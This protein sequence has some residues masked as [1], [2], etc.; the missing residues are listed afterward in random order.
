MKR[1]EFLEN[2]A[3]GAGVLALG[4]AVPAFT[5]EKKNKPKKEFS[6]DPTAIIPLT[7]KVSCTR[8]GFGTGMRGYY[9]ESD[10]TKMG[11]KNAVELLQFA[12]DQNVRL[13]DMADLYG[14]HHYVSRALKG[15]PRDSYAMISKVWMHPGGLHEETR[16]G[17]DVTLKR[18][19]RECNTDY[20]DILQ[21]HCMNDGEWSTR[22]AKQMDEME[23][24]KEEGLILAHGVSCHANSALETAATT[25]WVDTAHVR[26]NHE[27]VKMDGSVDDVVKVANACHD[28]GIGMIAMKVIGEGAFAD[29]LEKRKKSITF[30]SGLDC[31]DVMIVGFYKKEHV[32]EFITNVR[33]SLEAMKAKNVG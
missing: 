4:N 23:K 3:L 2:A 24:L 1:R 15:K 22:Y 6:T 27:G 8:I 25:P 33:E 14:T 18:F 21:I 11:E 28:S 31:I 13:F 32:T 26:I 20:L 10:L 7:E 30:V 29:S 17:V 19:L 5:A 16:P 12:Y 9:R